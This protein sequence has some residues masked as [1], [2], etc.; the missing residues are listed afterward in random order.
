MN[1]VYLFLVCLI[2]TYKLN[3]K[4]KKEI[5][6]TNNLDQIYQTKLQKEFLATSDF[7][8]V[9]RCT[10][11]INEKSIINKYREINSFSEKQTDLIKKIDQQYYCSSVKPLYTI[12]L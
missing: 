1:V 4:N 10:S 2:S 9:F 8:C 11:E 7:T 3:G 5:L 6:T 12:K